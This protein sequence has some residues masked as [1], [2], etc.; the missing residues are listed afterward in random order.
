[1][2]KCHLIHRSWCT[3]P[4]R[5]LL[6]L[7]LVLHWRWFDFALL[8]A[9]FEISCFDFYPKQVWMSVLDPTHVISMQ[10]ALT[11]LAVTVVHVNSDS[12][13]MAPI[14]QVMACVQAPPGMYAWQCKTANFTLDFSLLRRACTNQR[15]DFWQRW[16]SIFFFCTKVFFWHW[17]PVVPSFSA[18]LEVEEK[19]EEEWSFWSTRRRRLQ[20]LY[21]TRSHHTCQNSKQKSS[22]CRACQPP[23]C[24]QLY[25]LDSLKSK[26]KRC[27][28]SVNTLNFHWISKCCLSTCF[29]F[30]QQVL[31]LLR[32]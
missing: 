26:R 5:V 4:S 2:I 16:I 7:M 15:R 20:L 25:N 1:M 11:L 13:A 18:V 28:T 17:S 3:T 24:T 8:V 22:G 23:P 29:Q 27:L 19:G 30:S 32:W 6:M 21:L 14:A 31:V 9:W 10:R 12:Q